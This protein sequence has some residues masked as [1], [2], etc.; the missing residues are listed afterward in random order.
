MEFK[1][2]GDRIEILPQRDGSTFIH[3]GMQLHM[4]DELW[5]EL[6]GRKHKATA[7]SYTH[8]TLPT[9]LLV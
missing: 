6:D 2:G 9:I 3:E 1:F 5:L 8:L 7:V 4:G